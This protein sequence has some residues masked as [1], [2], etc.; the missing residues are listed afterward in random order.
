MH[1]DPLA[2][3]ADTMRQLGYQTVDQLVEWLVTAEDQPALRRAT[4]REMEQRLREPA[5]LVA[6]P[7]A[8]LLSRLDRDVLPFMARNDHPR[9]FGYIPGSGTWPAALGDFIASACNI[10][11]GS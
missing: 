7:F 4:R 11:A 3:D 2:L 1:T 9:F 10:D 5:P 6:Q 8:T